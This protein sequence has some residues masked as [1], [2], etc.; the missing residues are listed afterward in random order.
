MENSKMEPNFTCA[1]CGNKDTNLVGSVSYFPGKEK[2]DIGAYME[3]S[4]ECN[5]CNTTTTRK[6]T[7][8]G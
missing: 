7:R 1:T 2:D 4:I 3:Y 5:K 8:N 6:D